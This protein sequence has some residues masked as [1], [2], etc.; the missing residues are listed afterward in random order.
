MKTAMEQ[1]WVEREVTVDRI[2]LLETLRANREKHIKEYNEA[3]IGYKA[4]ALVLLDRLKD[5]IIESVNW[6]YV[7][8]QKRI[9]AFDP[10]EPMTDHVSLTG[11]TSF[12]LKVPRSYERSYDVAIRMAE[13]EVSETITLKQSQ[14]QCFVL[15]DWDWKTEFTH[16]N[17]AYG[18]KF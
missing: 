17:K 8:T 9:E 15:D 10:D 6:H 16:L 14:F 3:V 11:S 7:S 2:K 18:V 4:Q 1:G 5:Q 12:S 13:W